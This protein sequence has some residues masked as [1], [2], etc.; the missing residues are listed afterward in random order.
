MNNIAFKTF[1]VTNYIKW[2]PIN[3][4]EE[5]CFNTIWVTEYTKWVP[6]YVMEEKMESCA[7][8]RTAVIIDDTG[9]KLIIH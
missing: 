9:S 5:H 8:T 3:V 2:V 4:I 1:W 6:N 7:A